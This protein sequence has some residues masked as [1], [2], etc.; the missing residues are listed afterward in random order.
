MLL[1]P[2]LIVKAGY[3]PHALTIIP[4]LPLESLG[5]QPGEQLIVSQSPGALAQPAFT[6]APASTTAA[7]PP[8]PA[9]SNPPQR[10]GAISGPSGGPDAIEVDGSYLVHRV[11][12]HGQC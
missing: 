1:H 10:A 5:L 4:E 11:S 2:T 7:A 8:V 9:I 12:E 3:P 6:P